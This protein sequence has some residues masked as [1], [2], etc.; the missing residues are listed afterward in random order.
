LV[1]SRLVQDWKNIGVRATLQLRSADDLQRA[2][3]SHDYEAL[4]YGISI[5]ADPDVFVYWDS[6]QN[7][8]R[9]AQLNFSHFSSK[10]ADASLEGARTRSDPALR[11]VKYKP[12]LQAWQQDSPALGL[13]QPH[14]NY[15]TH[16][17]LYGL[18]AHTINSDIDRYNNVQNWMVREAAV[19]Q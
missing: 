8:P 14:Y 1:T 11:T 19:T 18:A 17:T 4:L 10:V 3:A 13:Y 6:S 15:V 7:D 2:I 16:G 5:G 9:T 12:F